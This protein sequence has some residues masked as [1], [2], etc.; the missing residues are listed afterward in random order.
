MVG[1]LVEQQD[2]GS[3]NRMRASST[4]RRWPPDMV[5]TGWDSSALPM[6]TDAAKRL[7]SASA[8]YPPLAVNSSSRRPKRRMR[9]SRS[10]PDAA[11]IL[12]RTCSI[13][14]WRVPMSRAISTRSSAVTPGSSSSGS[15]LSCDR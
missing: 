12:R 3:A 13:R 2:V 4:R 9:R 6:P 14:R 15:L 10:L 7:A 11:S 1:R 8:T 5:A